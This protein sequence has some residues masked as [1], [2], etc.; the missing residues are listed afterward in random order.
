MVHLI[1]KRIT[2]SR[3]PTNGRRR[4]VSPEECSASSAVSMFNRIRNQL[5]SS[6][7]GGKLPCSLVL[8]YR[9][10]NL[11]WKRQGNHSTTESSWNSSICDFIR[12][13]RNE[14]SRPLC[15]CTIGVGYFLSLLRVELAPEVSDSCTHSVYLFERSSFRV[16]SSFSLDLRFFS[17]FI[18][19]CCRHRSNCV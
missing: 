5:P 16:Q 13:E 15:E 10:V 17:P 3:H 14:T 19:F 2:I 9:R 7:S 1:R 11:S 12:G 18:C 6:W 4:V 8:S